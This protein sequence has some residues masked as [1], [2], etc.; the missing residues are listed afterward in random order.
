VAVYLALSGQRPFLVKQSRSNHRQALI[1]K[2]ITAANVVFDPRF[3][4]EY[5]E[6][7][8]FIRAILIADPSQRPSAA[9]LFNH[10]ALTEVS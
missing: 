8:E 5:P 4:V 1:A 9:E 6:A 7:E 2:K 10:S 3:W